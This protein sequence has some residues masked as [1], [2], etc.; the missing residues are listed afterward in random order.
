MPLEHMDRLRAAHPVQHTTEPART[1]VRLG[2]Q[3][4]TSPRELEDLGHGVL[5]EAA[6]HDG[7]SHAA[8][9]PPA[10]GQRD[11]RADRRRRNVT[12]H[13]ADILRTPPPGLRERGRPCLPAQA[14]DD[15]GACFGPFSTIDPQ[16]CRRLVQSVLFIYLASDRSDSR[17]IVNE[18]IGK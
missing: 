17:K 2:S 18:I 12:R 8:D 16:T 4:A 9:L 11:H 15:S 14:Q 1:R 10:D 5:D 7:V 3:L 6:R 13:G